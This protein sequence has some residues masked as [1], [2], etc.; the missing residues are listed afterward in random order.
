M[1]L[2]WL[3]CVSLVLVGLFF[4]RELRKALREVRLHLFGVRVRARRLDPQARLPRFG[5]APPCENLLPSFRVVTR[6]GPGP[7]PPLAD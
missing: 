3:L 1:T 6:A 2:F 7:S 4:R 5:D